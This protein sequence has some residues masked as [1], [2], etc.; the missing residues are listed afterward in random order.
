MFLNRDTTIDGAI[1]DN[2]LDI[3]N[4]LLDKYYNN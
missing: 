2:M 1:K 3:S 4:N